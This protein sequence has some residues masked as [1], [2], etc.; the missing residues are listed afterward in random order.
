L[1][2][3]NETLTRI[4]AGRYALGTRRPIRDATLDHGPQKSFIF[5]IKEG[6]EEFCGVKSYYL[7]RC[8]S[9]FIKVR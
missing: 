4:N 8:A 1:Q 2:L 7:L 5:N 6:W 9:L 3:R